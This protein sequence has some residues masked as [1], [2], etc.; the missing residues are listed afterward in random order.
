MTK[1]ASLVQE[2]GYIPL[3]PKAYELAQARFKGQKVG[4]MFAGEGSK[5]GVT[6]EDLLARE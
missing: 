5:I 4:S 1:G 2:A 6:V 3:P